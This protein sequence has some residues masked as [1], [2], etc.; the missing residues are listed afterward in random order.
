MEADLGKGKHPV[1]AAKFARI[2]V[3]QAAE[4]ASAVSLINRSETPPITITSAGIAGPGPSIARSLSIDSHST[5]AHSLR[6]ALTG[7]RKPPPSS[8]VSRRLL[9]KP[10]KSSLGLNQGHQRSVSSTVPTDGGARL[11]MDTN[12][13]QARAGSVNGLPIE[14]KSV[15]DDDF[16]ALLNSGQTLKVSLTPGRLKNFDVSRDRYPPSLRLPLSVKTH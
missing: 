12:G 3:S 2:P 11:S 9:K 1:N 15:R 7:H 16:D 10:S 4:Q 5:P 8:L 13:D 6:A 14:G